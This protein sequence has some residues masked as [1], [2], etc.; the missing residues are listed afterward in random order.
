MNIADRA[1]HLKRSGIDGRVAFDI[2]YAERRQRRSG[3]V[4]PFDKHLIE[5][6]QA[7]TRK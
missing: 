2:A 5:Q 1:R 6:G 4:D 3:R 7:A